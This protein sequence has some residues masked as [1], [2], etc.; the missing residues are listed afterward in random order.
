VGLW[1]T[2]FI[3]GA[4]S[5]SVMILASQYLEPPPEGWVPKG[6]IEKQQNGQVK[7]KQDLSQ[8]TANEAIK[9]RRFW[10]LCIML[11]INITCGIAILAVASPMPQEVTE[12]TD[13]AAATM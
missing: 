13:L 4:V 3:V 6:F 2:C 9:S 5:F 8:L 11:F 10:M 12:M 7:V 1:S